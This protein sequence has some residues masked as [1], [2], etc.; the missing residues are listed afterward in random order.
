[1]LDFKNMSLFMSSGLSSRLLL[2]KSACSHI[3][4]HSLL[5][6]T[7]GTAKSQKASLASFVCFWVTHDQY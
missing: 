4:T 2:I 7:A 3:F 5:A 6:P 1:M